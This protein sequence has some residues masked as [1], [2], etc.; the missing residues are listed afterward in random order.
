MK[1]NSPLFDSIRV[2][3]SKDR[4]L[5]ND[6]PVCEWADCKEKATNLAPKG[7]ELERP[8]ALLRQ[9]RARIQSVL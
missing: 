4:R 5:K 1:I 3:P 7:R 6:G 2:K 8:L 9:A